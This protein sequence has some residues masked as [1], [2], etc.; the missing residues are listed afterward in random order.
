VVGS[1]MVVA[2]FMVVGWGKVVQIES[3]NSW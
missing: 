2:G 1:M 3:G